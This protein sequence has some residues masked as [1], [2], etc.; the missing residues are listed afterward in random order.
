MATKIPSRFSEFFTDVFVVIDDATGQARKPILAP[1]MKAFFDKAAPPGKFPARD[2][3]I[4]LKKKRGKSVIGAALAVHTA[5]V[6]PNSEIIFSNNSYVQGLG[7]CYAAA[8]FAV[9]HSPLLSK[10]AEIQKDRLKFDNGSEAYVVSAVAKSVAG[11][12]ARLTV[13]DEGWGLGRDDELRFTELQPLPFEGRAARVTISY[14][15]IVG[16]SIVL[17]RLWKQTLEGKRLFK[18]WPIYHN[19]D[20]G[21][22]G[23]IEGEENCAFLGWPTKKVLAQI[24]ATSRP[25]D[26]QRLWENT[27]TSGRD[28]PLIAPEAY[29]EL[30]DVNTD[31]LDPRHM[32][33]RKT[34]GG[35]DI[36]T[37]RASSGIVYAMQSGDYVDVLRAVEFEPKKVKGGKKEVNLKEVEDEITLMYGLG[38]MHM[39]CFDPHQAQYLV[40]RLETLCPHLTL[41]PIAQGAPRYTTDGVLIDLCR[42]K[43]LRIAPGLKDLRTHMLNA[44]LTVTKTGTRIDRA[45]RGR[46]NDLA[47]ALAM[48][49]SKAIET[50]YVLPS[51]KVEPFN[52]FYDGSAPDYWFDTMNGDW[53]ATEGGGIWNADLA[54]NVSTIAARSR[55][56][57]GTTWQNCP[58]RARGCK[59]CTAEL[60]KAGLYRARDPDEWLAKHGFYTLNNREEINE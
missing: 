1:A 17:D 43:S 40:Q 37:T 30:I 9:K 5:I 35:L 36:G 27:W 57:K 25:W 6:F 44:E 7:R 24:K 14:A 23:I 54:R 21:V 18:K 34:I 2:I 45:P 49:A 16:E 47:V 41:V 19:K 51:V 42:E 29:D 39:L 56:P 20:A 53:V 55:H 22:I 28:I 10:H 26:F 60:D 11:H 58:N 3:L 50:P 38:S 8:V 46:P 32:D 4:G 48:A 59:S 52:K 31:P 33:V 12:G 15:G 13:I